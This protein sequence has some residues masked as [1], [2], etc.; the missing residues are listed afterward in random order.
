M[1]AYVITFFDM[2]GTLIAGVGCGLV[3]LLLGAVLGQGRLARMGFGVC[4]IGGL[5]QGF[6][7]AAPVACVFC[8]LIVVLTVTTA[9]RRRQLREATDPVSRHSLLVEARPQPGAP[10]GG[11]PPPDPGEI[12]RLIRGTRPSLSVPGAPA[13][14]RCGTTTLRPGVRGAG[15]TSVE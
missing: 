1:F 6:L 4:L 15:P 7:F 14:S 8:L 3:P 11:N 9:E 10:A 2:F 5:G 13:S 12:R